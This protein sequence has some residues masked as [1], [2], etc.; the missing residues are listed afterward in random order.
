MNAAAVQDAHPPAAV[1]R[2]VNPIMRT[3]LRTPVARLLAD[4]A[5]IE[6]TGRR[7]GR[8]YRVPVGWHGLDGTTTVFTP[9]RW[10]ANF[11]GGVAADVRHRGRSRQMTGTL[12]TDPTAV[13]HALQRVLDAGTPPRRIG[14]SIAPGHTL[15]E[16]DVTSTHRAM[17]RFQPAAD[18]APPVASSIAGTQLS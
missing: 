7:S 13:A 10:R 11:A 6:F 2:V 8:R 18:A 1:I 12:V 4:V 15:T 16:D 5:L 14:L 17:I 9:A 3:L